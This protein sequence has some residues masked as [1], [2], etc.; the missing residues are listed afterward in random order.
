MFTK[1]E[2]V[3]VYHKEALNNYTMVASTPSPKNTVE[4]I[5]YYYIIAA[6]E[7]EKKSQREAICSNQENHLS[8]ATFINN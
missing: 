5:C 1:G 6:K 8:V 4:S 3:L 2:E 7:E